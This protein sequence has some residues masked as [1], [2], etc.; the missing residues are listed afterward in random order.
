[1]RFVRAKSDS[2]A[3]LKEFQNRAEATFVFYCN[4]ERLKFD[5]AGA[6]V[7]FVSGADI[8]KILSII[9]EKAP[10]L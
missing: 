5:Q 6:E 10:K 8:P 9:T 7:E 2:I 4:G 1:M 3:G